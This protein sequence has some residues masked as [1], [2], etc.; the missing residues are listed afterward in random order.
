MSRAADYNEREAEAGRLTFAHRR[1][2]IEAGARAVQA[3]NGLAVDGMAGP[4]TRAVLDHLAGHA[5]PQSVDEFWAAYGKTTWTEGERGRVVLPEEWVASHI[6]TVTLHTNQRRSMH[7]VA[8]ADFADTFRRACEASSYTPSSVQ[9]WVPRHVGWS[10]ERS[11]SLHTFGVAVDFD[12]AD[13]RM[14]G[15]RRDRSPSLLRQHI[16]FVEVFEAAGWTWG[17]RWRMK[18]DMHFQR[19]GSV[20]IK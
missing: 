18:D 17:G 14:G 8:A 16:A 9:T 11:L 10:A 4:S 7:R 3:D 12:P 6:T 2:L 1:A 5:V 13:N 15:V 19:A 20:V